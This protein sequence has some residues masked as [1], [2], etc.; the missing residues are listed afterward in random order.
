M[1]NS[2]GTGQLGH[3]EPLGKPT[4]AW[5]NVDGPWRDVSEAMLQPFTEQGLADE[6]REAGAK[7]EQH[8]GRPWLVSSLGLYTGVHLA[9][10]FSAQEAKRPSPRALAY[11]VVLTDADVARANAALPA[12]ILAN[13]ADFSSAQL[14]SNRRYHLRKC[15]RT[16]RSFRSWTWR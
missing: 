14:S 3:Q 6:F 13:V 5:S 2:S 8:R 15:R 4:G 1:P 10:R 16:C 12:H 11:R 9:A 7:V